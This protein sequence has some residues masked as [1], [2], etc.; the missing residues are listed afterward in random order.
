MSGSFVLALDEGSSSCRSILV[1]A[2]GG[3]HGEQRADV[4]WNTPRPSWVELDPVRLWQDQLCTVRRSMTQVGATGRDLAAVA[5]TTHRETSMLWD[6]ATGEPVHPAVV[7]ISKQSDEIVRR[8]SAEGLDELFRQRTGL[9]NDSF[10]SA[11]KVAWMLEHVPG[12]RRRAE[13]G[14]IAFGTPDTW[15][16]WNLTGG[17]SHLT[18]HTCASRTALFNL[19]ALAWDEELCAILGIPMEIFPDAVAS[20]SDFGLSSAD[21][22][23]AEVPVRAVIADQQAGL[24]GQA[25]YAP[26]SAKNTF[27]TAGVL[28][29][30][31][32][33]KPVL[34]DGLTSSVGWTIRGTTDYE[35]EGVVFHSGQTLS[36]MKDNLKLFRTNDEIEALSRA[37]PDSGG[38][39]VVPA[40]GGMCAPHWDREAKAAVVGLT[41][42]STAAHV[43]RA[44]MDSMAFQTADIIDALEAGGMPVDVLK[45]D[46]GSA[47]SDLLCQL[48]ADLSGK[49]IQRP[50]SLE[51]TAL[52]AAFVAGLGVGLW[53]GIVDLEQT[54]TCEREFIPLIDEAT[55]EARHA[56]WRE[57]LDRTLPRRFA[58][59]RS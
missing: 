11:A 31:A 4:V 50:T 40:F 14:E 20:D 3:M 53:D 55:R 1:D 37:V 18:D 56:G 5:V 16:L 38:V 24:F 45:V 9:F 46:G 43:V 52:G 51:R 39:Y 23:G 19:E 58:A 22:L 28:T 27:G 47:R 34:V 15:L 8:W 10:F 33:E 30:N 41:L 29:V 57:A 36:W 44:G 54:W 26:G 42:E 13:A 21:V 25:G 49:V 48:T 2:S 6:R 7:W 32:G 12:V 17:R 59:A 35:L